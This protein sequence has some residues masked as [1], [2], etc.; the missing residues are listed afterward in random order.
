[1]GIAQGTRPYSVGM[2]AIA[3]RLNIMKRVILFLIV[4]LTH[5]VSWSAEPI[6]KSLKDMKLD[7][8]SL[9]SEQTCQYKWMSVS[10]KGTKMQSNDYATLKL[11]TKVQKEKLELHDTITLVPAHGGM[12]FDRKL[13]YP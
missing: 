12:I 11:S 6:R 4:A 1:M 3:H 8:K 2:K 10:Q 5:T 9:G 13:S 7:L